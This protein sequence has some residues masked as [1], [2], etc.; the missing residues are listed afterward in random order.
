LGLLDFMRFSIRELHLSVYHRT[1]SGN[2][3]QAVVQ[4]VNSALLSHR[5]FGGSIRQHRPKNAHIN[6]RDSLMQKWYI[7]GTVPNMYHFFARSCKPT[8]FVIK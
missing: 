5:L 2:P 3:R 6:I 4:F 8:S 1:P 7:L